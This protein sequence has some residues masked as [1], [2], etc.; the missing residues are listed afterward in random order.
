MTKK[1]IVLMVFS[2]ILL[3]A[4][5]FI[6]R[7]IP[8]LAASILITFLIS[9]LAWSFLSLGKARLT[10]TINMS[11]IEDQE[12]EVELTLENRNIFPR[13][14][15]EV[16]DFFTPKVNPPLWQ[17]SLVGTME[18][19][20]PLK[21]SYQA[22]CPKRGLY[23]IGPCYLISQ[24]PFGL[25]RLRRRFD[26]YSKLMVL[27]KTFPIT[28][29]PA[30]IKGT[31]PWFGLETARISGEVI[32]FYGIR[33][34]QQR[35]GMRRIH[36]PS[37]ARLGTLTAK[38]YEKATV[39]DA[40]IVLDLH[41]ESDLGIGKESSLEYGTRIAASIAKFLLTEKE[42]LVQFIA[43]GRESLV[44]PFGKGLSQQYRILETLA[45]AKADGAYKLG[46]VLNEMAYI[47]PADSTLIVI[48]LD[49][50]REA[51]E[52]LAQFRWKWVTM[53]LIVLVSSTF[54]WVPDTQTILR[55][56]SEFEAI[57]KALG[58]KIYYICQGEDLQKKF[59]EQPI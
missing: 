2:L 38:Q 56:K 23:Y 9:S 13:D 19:K 20:K 43:Y 4:A 12:L 15:I 11:A 18:A 39:S 45:T 44:I 36:W 54:A 27:P 46:Q 17:T 24:D 50:D 26:I 33:E 58:A 51:L 29:F 37:T 48:T 14:L 21:W 30:L 41:R 6:K 49:T 22:K 3:V 42:S 35:D 16:V 40:T 55:K 47:I 57:S 28:N 32:E 53:I 25:F 34:Y 52:T 1:A 59:Q 5:W 31:R 8:Y 10:R 7:P